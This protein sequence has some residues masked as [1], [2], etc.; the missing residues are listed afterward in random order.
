MKPT[1]KKRKT[2]GDVPGS[3]S[4]SDDYDTPPEGLD[5]TNTRMTTQEI[6]EFNPQTESQTEK[7]LDGIVSPLSPLTDGTIDFDDPHQFTPGLADTQ[8]SNSPQEIKTPE[9]VADSQEL[10]ESDLAFADLLAQRNP[11]PMSEMT[12]V[13]NVEENRN[14]Y[15]HIK[16]NI[17]SNEWLDEFYQNYQ[18]ED[19]TTTN[20]VPNA[21][22]FVAALR[23][24]KHDQKFLEG[25]ETDRIVSFQFKTRQLDRNFSRNMAFL[26]KT[27]SAIP[28]QKIEKLKTSICCVED[29]VDLNKVDKD[30][31]L[32][33]LHLIE[34][35]I[36]KEINSDSV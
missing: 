8:P 13:E 28:G 2:F 25:A 4:S 34:E 11:S 1:T 33:R 31:A 6:R 36:K 16:C 3:N 27:A 15:D 14:K 23:K 5:L 29:R 19:R 18:K 17:R 12:D 7:R 32:S 20:Y 26:E 10:N 24:I 30:V 35:E 9:P 22:Q 21:G